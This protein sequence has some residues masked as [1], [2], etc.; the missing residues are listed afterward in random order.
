MGGLV[1]LVLLCGPGP[2]FADE[3]TLKE[4]ATGVSFPVTSSAGLTLLGVGVRKKLVFNVYAAA[5]YV[6]GP[7]LRDASGGDNSLKKLNRAMLFGTFRRRLVLHFVR[8]VPAE[9]VRA[10]FQDSL[11]NNMTKEDY[12]AE[13]ESI[14]RFLDSCEDIGKFDSFSF[15]S[16]GSLVKVRLGTRTL[17][18]ARSLR[19]VRGMWGSYFGRRPID[20][21]LRKNLLQMRRAEVLGSGPP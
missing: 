18:G 9:K 3:S 2:V 12:E 21:A 4:P 7:G 15:E 14:T 8:P 16:S 10:A 17:F 1:W 6:D 11:T 5:L 20:E 19:L 13:E